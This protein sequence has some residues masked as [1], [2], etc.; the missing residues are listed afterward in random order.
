MEY[1][2][3]PI[4]SPLSLSRSWT[5]EAVCRWRFFSSLHFKTNAFMPFRSCIRGEK[6]EPFLLAEKSTQNAN[7]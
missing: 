7:E 3:G 4:Q 1:S 6:V 5:N 2:T